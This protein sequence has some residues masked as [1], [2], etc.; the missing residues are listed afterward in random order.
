MVS[1]TQSRFAQIIFLSRQLYEFLKP[2]R[3][4]KKAEIMRILP[5]L[6][7][8]T[9]VLAAGAA[10]KIKIACVG[11]SITYGYGLS[12]PTTQSYPGRLQTLFGTG[13]YT[14]ENDGVNAT[15]LLKNGD[16][17][18]WKNGRLPQVFSFQPTI[19]TI[20]LGTNDTK[21]QN[22]DSHNQEF[23]R[24]Y[25][26]MIDTLS[27][28]ASKPKIWL[29]LPV[30]VFNNATAISWGIRDSIIKK[31]IPII[32]QIG[33]ERGVPVIDVNTPLLAFPQ[34]FS[35][36][37]VHP[38]AAGEDTIAHVIYR[39]LLAATATNPENAAIQG[40]PPRHQE[41]WAGIGFPSPIEFSPSPRLFDLSGR[42]LCRDRR[43]ERTGRPVS[44][45]YILNN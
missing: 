42:R 13:N 37:G 35:V 4:F 5:M 19:V 23:K 9:L 12:S 24:D 27:S 6:F 40:V 11:N 22:W 32:K 2:Q 25:L 8:T 7:V 36:D 30:P 33:S 39:V 3:F 41:T 15:T 38:N 34:Y 18:Y 1:F 20:K 10:T 28:M 44:K 26:A 29:V 16:N 43:L 31:I 21:P 45:W 14:V 17:P